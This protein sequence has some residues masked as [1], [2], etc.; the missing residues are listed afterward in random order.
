[1]KEDIAAGGHLAHQP[2]AHTSAA[3][4]QAGTHIDSSRLSTGSRRSPVRLPLRHC[5]A[6]QFHC[7]G[8]VVPL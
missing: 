6:W 8:N 5:L 4:Q 2:G 7:M 3:M 1:M